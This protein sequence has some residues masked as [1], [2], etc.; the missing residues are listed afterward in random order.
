MV[1]VRGYVPFEALEERHILWTWF[2]LLV[3]HYGMDYEIGTADNT[4]RKKV[5]GAIEITKQKYTD[6]PSVLVKFSFAVELCRLKRASVLNPPTGRQLS[7]I[8]KRSGKEQGSEAVPF[9]YTPLT[10]SCS[11]RKGVAWK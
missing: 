8:W 4:I 7:K 5:C 2:A 10:L 1:L 11:R 6:K 3:G 9:N